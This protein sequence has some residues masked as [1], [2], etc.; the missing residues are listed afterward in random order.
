MDIPLWWCT[1][2]GSIFGFGNLNAVEDYVDYNHSRYVSE[3]RSGENETKR[4]LIL[5]PR[6]FWRRCCAGYRYLANCVET[7]GRQS[8]SK[9]IVHNRYVDDLAKKGALFVNER[10]RS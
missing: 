1:K 8:S 4:V 9:E 7:F 10:T 6:G 3:D 2:V 5:K